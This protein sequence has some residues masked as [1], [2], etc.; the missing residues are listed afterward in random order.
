MGKKAEEMKEL[1]GHL[2]DGS[3]SEA[4]EDVHRPLPPEILIDAKQDRI[5][6]E[7]RSERKLVVKR[8]HFRKT[9]SPLK[10]S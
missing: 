6:T 3:E 1:M 10:F 4:S 8:I 7:K 5:H 9:T 2:N